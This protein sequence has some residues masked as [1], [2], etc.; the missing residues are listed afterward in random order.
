MELL[1][2]KRAAFGMLVST[3]KRLLKSKGRAEV[4]QLQIE[5]MIDRGVARKLTQDELNNYKGPAHYLSHHEVL[6]PDSKSTPFRIV[7]NS[8]SSYMGQVLNEFWAK[9]LDLPNSL[10]GILIR[11]RENNIALIGITG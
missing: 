3:E 9:G 1:N 8:S 10:L 5:D 11:F 7:F 6:K 2:N 4:Y